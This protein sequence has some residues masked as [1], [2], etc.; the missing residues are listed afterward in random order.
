[1]KQQNSKQ[2]QH[3]S[4]PAEIEMIRGRCSKFREGL[5]ALHNDKGRTLEV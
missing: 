4:V 1:M 3:R 2:Q 5:F